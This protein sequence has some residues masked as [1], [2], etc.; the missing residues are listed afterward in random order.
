M[1]DSGGDCEEVAVAADELDEPPDDDADGNDSDLGRVAIDG[2]ADRAEDE[3]AEA[4]AAAAAAAAVGDLALRMRA[5]R[6][7][8]G[9]G[10]PSRW[11][12]LS[13]DCMIDS[14]R[15]MILPLLPP[16][17]L[18]LDGALAVAAVFEVDGCME[19]D[20]AGWWMAVAVLCSSTRKPYCFA[21]LLSLLVAASM[22]DSRG[23]RLRLV[24]DRTG[25]AATDELGETR[26]NEPSAELEADVD[27]MS[28]LRI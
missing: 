27:P 17:E 4:A 20:V 1:L 12:E 7:C 8:F 13:N 6:G 26:L 21:L 5:S 28:D 15:R 16:L 10:V 23:R 25:E 9:S 19:S 22:A 14:R 18:R 11:D 3:A 2:R 24:L